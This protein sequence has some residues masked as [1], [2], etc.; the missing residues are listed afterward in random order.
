MKICL[1]PRR[2]VKAFCWKTLD[3]LEDFMVDVLQH[4]AFY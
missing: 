1:E 3:G 4:K 2:L